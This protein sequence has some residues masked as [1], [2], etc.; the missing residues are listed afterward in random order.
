M[1]R[2]TLFV[3]I[4]AL[5]AGTASAQDGHWTVGLIS[6]HQHNFKAD[7][8][9]SEMD[10]PMGYG[11]SLGYTINQYATFGVTATYYNAD[12]ESSLGDETLWRSSF[13]TYLF[14]FQWDRVRPFVSAGLVYSHQ[15]LDFNGGTNETKNLLQMR[16]GLGLDVVIVPGVH[17]NLES[18]FYSDG[19]NYL[20]AV[21]SFGFR[22]IF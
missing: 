19:L 6:S 2:L 12:L 18:A 8:R 16:H 9:L 21:N 3:M 13:S 10:N 7:H 17:L 1:K 20:G 22:Y 11:L 4:L 15:N 5:A 14:P